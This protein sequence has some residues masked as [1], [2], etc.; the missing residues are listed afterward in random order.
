MGMLRTVGVCVQVIV[1]VA[2]ATRV[3]TAA[4]A[5]EALV[6]DAAENRE[7]AVIETLLKT[8]VDVNAAQVDGMTALHWAVYHDDF[9]TAKLLVNAGADVR[10]ENRYGV[11]PI[12]LASTNGNGFL[13]DLLLESG[14]DSNTV[15]SG[16]ESVLM[17][18]SYAGSLD[19]V[20]SL[21]RHGAD[22]NATEHRNQTALMWAAAEGHALVVDA[23]L[24]AGADVHAKL[25]SGFTSMFFAVR[26]GRIEVV[27]RLL[28]AG[29][30]V[31][32]LLE[33]DKDAVCAWC[34]TRSARPVNDGMSPLL[35]A[36]R[37]GHFEL[38]LS[39]VDAGADPND[40]RTGFSPIHSVSWTRK[41]DASDTGNP[42]PVG[43]GNVTS[44]E[45]VRGMVER[46]ADVNLRLEQPKGR[47]PQ[48]A[49]RLSNE[50]ATAF[51]MAADRA[52]VAFMRLLVELGA[53]PFMPNI[54][55][56]TPL[57]A[58]AGLGTTAP[59]E[60]AGTEPEAYEAVELLL[61]LGA[62]IDAIDENGDT[63]MHGA[64]YGNFPTVVELL[65]RHAA[66]STIWKEKNERGLTP[67]FI[68]E[69]Y[70]G[71][72]F[73]LSRPTTEA[74]TRVMMA[75]GLSTAGERPA[76]RDIYEEKPEPQPEL[77]KP[78]QIGKSKVSQP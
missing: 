17:T 71:G 2:L 51:L 55:F 62:D 32:A 4:A 10:L 24:D 68:A 1:F 11:A 69:G 72:G 49:S 15:L 27:H 77:L 35:L 39:L 5:G 57:M 25:Y 73:K 14:A 3:G 8:G 60:E 46:G 48:T 29:T 31:N 18:A 70:R 23:L 22:P 12:S 53:D 38:G 21:L 41:P 45:F 13:V 63:P 42:S 50:G 20:E 6:A 74:V 36:V 43:S 28:Q 47:P 9:Q 54:E 33:R 40:Q 34:D 78:A 59:L 65:A 7:A 52:D 76:I 61:D 75:D 58:A 44:L 64:A 66:D 26:E 56:T 37:N 30:D 19:V 67:L 16:G